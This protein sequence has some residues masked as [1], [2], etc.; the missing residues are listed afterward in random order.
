MKSLYWKR[1]MEAAG[2]C[3]LCALLAAAGTHTRNI[4]QTKNETAHEN[5]TTWEQAENTPFGKYPKLLTYT[6]G[7]VTAEDNANMPKGDTY[8]DNKR[9]I[10]AV[11]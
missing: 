3:A 8:E 4:R 1:V 9:V 7:K 2:V 11:C 6:L 5:Q 10:F